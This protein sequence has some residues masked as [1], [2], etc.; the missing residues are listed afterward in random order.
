MECVV[1]WDDEVRLWPCWRDCE[2]GLVNA[3]L[4]RLETAVRSPDLRK[5][6]T[7]FLWLKRTSSKQN[8]PRCSRATHEQSDSCGPGTRE[9]VV[10]RYPNT[11]G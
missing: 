2:L 7:S 9:K 5:R 1:R 8:R 11:T 4:W 3:I 6:I 10:R